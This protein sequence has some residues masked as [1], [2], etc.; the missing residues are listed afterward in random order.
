LPPKRKSANLV[1]I[2]EDKSFRVL[3][4]SRRD[5]KEYFRIR[6]WYVGG[7]RKTVSVADKEEAIAA[8]QSIWEHYLMNPN[9]IS[10]K[11]YKTLEELS[12]AFYSRSSIRPKT[13]RYYQQAL[14]EFSSFVGSW[15]SF[16]RITPADIEAFLNSLTCK[17]ISKQSKLRAIKTLFNYAI[18]N[19]L[20]EVSPASRFSIK[21][22]HQIRPYLLP[23]E[24][25]AY[26][27]ACKPAFYPR[28]LFTLE[29]A[30]RVGEIVNLKWSSVFLER[31]KPFVVFQANSDTDHQPKWGKRGAVPLSKTAIE[32]LHLA[33]KLWKHS[34]YVF[35]DKFLKNTTNLCRDS[36][37]A[38]RKAG[39]TDIDFHGMRRS[40]AIR[41]LMNGVPIHVVSQL[42][43]H[44]SIDITVRH[45]GWL[46]TDE[47]A[48]HIERF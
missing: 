10:A 38:A 17:D 45:Y 40:A 31:E 27:E 7:K 22:T 39:T 29:T 48:R 41:W 33:R 3:V 5:R 26:L 20:M 2:Q 32:S 18:K 37:L 9:R 35:S 6:Y 19:G 30:C 28:A 8:A 4:E 44:S 25:E 14:T 36:H 23:N 21:T 46:L 15:R 34:E 43:R 13:K 47:L 12:E 24:F 16:K 1:W 11:S 42:L